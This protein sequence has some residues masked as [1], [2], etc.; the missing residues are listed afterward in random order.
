VVGTFTI[1]AGTFTENQVCSLVT[2]PGSYQVATGKLTVGSLEGMSLAPTGTYS[3]SLTSAEFLSRTIMTS[4]VGVS[5]ITFQDDRGITNTLQG[6]VNIVA[7][8]NLR[9]TYDS[10]SNTLTLDA[11][12]GLGLNTACVEPTYITRINGVTPDENGNIS[13]LGVGCT[14]ITTSS[15]ASLTIND[16]C[17][18]P[19]SGCTDLATL[20]ARLTQLES[21]LTSLQ[22]YFQFLQ[23]AQSNFDAATNASA[24]CSC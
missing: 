19:C 2:S 24:N 1:E 10:G 12:E 8:T 15:S 16:E 23:G 6:N 14:G 21:D 3:F 17:C 7:R 4:L 11:G 5:S 20:T 13:I 22:S 18:V 9:F